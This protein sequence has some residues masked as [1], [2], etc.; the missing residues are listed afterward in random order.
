MN[1]NEST[2]TRDHDPKRFDVFIAYNSADRKQ[3]EWLCQQ[4]Q[5]RRV[6]VWVD[7]QQNLLGERLDQ[8]IAEGIR[9][10]R[11]G[12]IAI[13]PNG[14]G[15]WQEWEQA[16]IGQLHI[17]KKIKLITVLLPGV[18]E[19]PKWLFTAVGAPLKF[20][21]A[22]DELEELDRLE[23]KIRD[24]HVAR[25]WDAYEIHVQVGSIGEGCFVATPLGLNDDRHASILRAVESAALNGSAPVRNTGAA[26]GDEATPDSEDAEATFYENIRQQ[27]LTARIVVINGVAAPASTAPA[28]EVVY[29]WGIAD[30]LGKPTIVVDDGS[31]SFPLA[32]VAEHRVTCRLDVVPGQD[33]FEQSLS[34]KIDAVSDSLVFPYLTARHRD[35]ICANHVQFMCLRPAFWRRVQRIIRFGTDI[36]DRIREVV[37]HAYRMEREALR[38]F[39]ASQE[40]VPS[41]ESRSG[42]QGWEAFEKSFHQDY[43]KAHEE[44]A[45]VLKKWVRDKEIENCFEFLTE[46][47][48]PPINQSARH[49]HAC[50]NNALGRL[51]AF[52]DSHDALLGHMGKA[53]PAE[54]LAQLKILCCGH[55]EHITEA[56]HLV[57]E[58]VVTLLEIISKEQKGIGGKTH[59][60]HAV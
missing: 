2:E 58:M 39:N 43:L 35:D 33:E 30:A 32:N 5:L 34:E 24:R 4:L 57:S 6:S 1:G 7:Y 40:V 42:E 48:R 44:I 23:G 37:K 51:R 21:D 60:Q 9:A 22:C 3:V 28:P 38:L 47:L 31:S 8:V 46:K 41:R 20:S 10:S 45:P 15:R 17:E 14:V 12:I 19:P 55:S 29:A 59:G 26:F 56:D 54:S 16:F 13:G 18:D 52:I 53:K 11:F 27:V 49:S 25:E 36:H 50:Y